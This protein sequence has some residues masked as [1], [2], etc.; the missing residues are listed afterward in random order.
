MK[1][2]LFFFSLMC[3]AFLNAQNFEMPSPKALV[4]NKFTSLEMYSGPDTAN[5]VFAW[6]KFDDKGRIIY[7][8]TLHSSDVK[9]YYTVY[10]YDRKGR[11]ATETDRSEDGKFISRKAYSYLKDSIRIQSCYNDKSDSTFLTLQYWL[12]PRN[13]VRRMIGYDKGGYE[14]F[15]MGGIFDKK[16]NVIGSFD[17]SAQTRIKNEYIFKKYRRISTYNQNGQ[18]INVVTLC[19]D[20]AGYFNELIDSVPASKTATHYKIER[21]NERGLVVSKNGVSLTNGEQAS[22]T[23]KYGIYHY[24]DPLIAPGPAAGPTLC[25]PTTPT[26]DATGLIRSAVVS[27]VCVPNDGAF[28]YTIFYRYK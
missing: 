13:N 9:P 27:N 12:D 25:Y 23:M 11:L 19:C 1:T 21:S 28:P 16:G 3:S 24:N 10:T 5:L 14:H 20:T 18:L 6:Y 15:D 22:W 4:K 7:Q 17:S 26:Y 2:R 8:K